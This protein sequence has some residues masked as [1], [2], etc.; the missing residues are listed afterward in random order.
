MSLARPWVAWRIG[1][2]ATIST[3]TRD[4][5]TPGGTPRLT[6]AALVNKT[7]RP[8]ST[9]SPSSRHTPHPTQ[10]RG[11]HTSRALQKRTGP[12]VSAAEDGTF[13]VVWTPLRRSCAHEQSDHANESALQNAIHLT[14]YQGSENPG[15]SGKHWRPRVPSLKDRG[16]GDDSRTI[17]AL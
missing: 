10:G 2:F 3:R 15:L 1:A 8:R 13:V 14:W 11:G 5:S 7:T 17:H 12:S 6:E 16:E 9:T 4:L